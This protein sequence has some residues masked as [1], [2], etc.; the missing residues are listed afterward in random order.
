MSGDPNSLIMEYDLK[1]EKEYYEALEYEF[2]LKSGCCPECGGNQI[3]LI[4]FSP[5]LDLWKCSSCEE[6]FS[7]P[8]EWFDQIEKARKV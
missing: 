6:E 8:P 5:N 3:E 7:S 4:G 2:Q 1:L